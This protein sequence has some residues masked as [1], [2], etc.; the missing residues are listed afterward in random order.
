MTC[1]GSFFLAASSQAQ[2]GTYDLGKWDW[3]MDAQQNIITWRTGSAQNQDQSYGP[4]NAWKDIYGIHSA[5]L[6]H[7]DLSG[8][9]KHGW[10]IL[11]GYGHQRH[12][13]SQ[14]RLDAPTADEKYPNN[15]FVSR[16]G[17]TPFL[18]WHP[19]DT[20]TTNNAHLYGYV[21][22]LFD[23]DL[24]TSTYGDWP[25]YKMFCAGHAFLPDG[26]LYLAGGDGDLYNSSN[27]VAG[28]VGLRLKAILD[29]WAFDPFNTNQS[30]SLWS[31]NNAMSEPRWYPTVT[32]LPSGKLLIL[33]GTHY[34]INGASAVVSET[35]EVYDPCTDSLNQRDLPAGTNEFLGF[36]YPRLHLVSYMNSEGNGLDT[37]RV[38]YTGFDKK[39]YWL[40]A[41]Q[42]DSEWEDYTQQRNRHRTWGSSVLLPNPVD[43]PQGLSQQVLKQVMVVGG[44]NGTTVTNTTEVMTF[45]HSGSLAIDWGPSMAHDRMHLNTILLPTGEVLAIGGINTRVNNWTY[46]NNVVFATELYTKNPSTGQYYWKSVAAAPNDPNNDDKDGDA[47]VDGTRVYHST[48][49]LLPDGSVLTAGSATK[50][51]SNPQ[52]IVNNHVPTIYSPPYLFKSE[53]CKRSSSER[54]QILDVSHSEVDYGNTFSV[55]Y[56]LPEDASGVQSVVFV[57]PGS[58][59]H[60]FNFEQRLI[61][62]RFQEGDPLLEV[63]APWDPA[64]APPGWYMLFVIDVNGVPSEAAWVRLKSAECEGEPTSL[65]HIELGG[66]AALVDFRSSRAS[67][68]F[69]HSGRI[70]GSVVGRSD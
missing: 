59:T 57:R 16:V 41:L 18:L 28:Y 54:T 20:N 63:T 26:R 36:L 68:T 35:H 40:D 69:A 30:Q 44:D 12:V 29:P 38:V 65:L 7:T 10:V 58:V 51:Q 60:S 42:P 22:Y 24:W 14:S 13:N 47:I 56:Q 11:W 33:G 62:L 64:I 32:A 49:L 19:K 15:Y 37:P 8:N 3:I 5:L 31:A 43:N 67:G 48:A 17:M 9:L 23:D 1:V 2:G 27:N 39:T 6:P 50:D 55:E 70:S 45:N 25:I 21:R 34:K 61:R 52:V 66:T 4:S 53:N 46:P